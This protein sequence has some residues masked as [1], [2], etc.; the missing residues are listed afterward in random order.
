VFQVFRL[1]GLIGTTNP[2][3]MQEIRIIAFSLKIGY[4]GNV[5]FG[6]H[7]LQHVPVSKPFD[8][9]LFEILE[10]ITLYCTLTDNR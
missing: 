3:G 2:P 7:Y 10:A 6:C 1:S 5:K 9:A 8:H 4:I